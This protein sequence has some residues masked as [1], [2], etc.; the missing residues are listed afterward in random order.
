MVRKN[1]GRSAFSESKLFFE[2]RERYFVDFGRVDRIQ[3]R[4]AGRNSD[5][6]EVRHFLLTEASRQAWITKQPEVS[7][8][9]TT[10]KTCGN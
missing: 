3:F 10:E 6:L 9:S 1:D 4:V 2:P 5:F 8:E 7:P